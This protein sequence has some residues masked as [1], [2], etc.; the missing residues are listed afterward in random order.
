VVKDVVPNVNKNVKGLAFFRD[1]DR[2][3]KL[4][5]FLVAYVNV[6]KVHCDC[7]FVNLLVN[8]PGGSS[9]LDIVTP[10]DIAYGAT[11][12]KNSVVV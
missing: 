10:S 5:G 8:N 12:L 2:M 7:Y 6:R 9:Y 4:M 11:L 1:T 3:E